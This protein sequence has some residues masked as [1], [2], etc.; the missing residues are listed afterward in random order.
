MDVSGSNTLLEALGIEIVECNKSRCV[1]TMPVDHR[2]KQ[3]FGLPHGGASVSSS[4]N[5]GE[6]G[7]RGSFRLNARSLLR[8]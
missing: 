6:H 2:T 5:S 3:P 8:Y 7:G 4:R 1:A